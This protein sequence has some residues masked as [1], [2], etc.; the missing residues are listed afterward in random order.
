MMLLSRFW[1]AILSVALAAAVAVLYISIHQH[2]RLREAAEA[3]AAA[4]QEL[5]APF[6]ADDTPEQ[7]DDDDFDDLDD[8][9]I[10]VEAKVAG[11]FWSVGLPVP[12]GWPRRGRRRASPAT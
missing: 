12:A 4:L 11:F 9:D 1:Y 5:I 6:I 7:D 10:F 2:N 3:T 8:A